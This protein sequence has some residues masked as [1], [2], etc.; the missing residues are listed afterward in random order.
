MANAGAGTNGSQFFLVYRDSMLPPTY[1]VFGAI[2]EAGLAVVDEMAAGA[3]ADGTD[4]G[5][6]T[7]PLTKESERQG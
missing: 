5:P 4:D 3:G 2:D 7:K 1:T 6:P